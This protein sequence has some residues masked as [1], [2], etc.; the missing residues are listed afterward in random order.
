MPF[1]IAPAG[2]IFQ[3]HL[4]QAIEGL[5]GVKTVAD[6]ILV[7]RNG[8]SK[9]EAIADHDRKLTSLLN[10]CREWK[11]K[12]NQAKIELKRTSIHYI[13]HVLTSDGVKA[14]PSKISSITEMKNPTD[15]SGVRRLL[16][17]ANYLAKF[18]LKSSDAAEPLRQ[19][20]PDDTDFV[21]EKVH[22]QAFAQIKRFITSPLVLKYYDPQAKLVL[23]CDASETRLGEAL[24]K[25]GKP[26]MYASRALTTTER[27][28]AK[29]EKELLPIVFR[30]ERYHQFTY[31]R[32]VMVESDQKPLETIFSKP[33][34]S[35]PKHLQ[36][37]LMR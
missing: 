14:D 17:T 13:G 15:T 3:G 9:S 1:G 19:L 24:M 29:I 11:I 37:M 32:H 25:D 12:L 27:N 31:G 26:V 28:Y 4:D 35:A 22:E 21:W 7:I 6:D 2:E 5:H 20:T 33:L 30:V 16:G 36:K 34:A 10:H 8:D 18:L 23:Q